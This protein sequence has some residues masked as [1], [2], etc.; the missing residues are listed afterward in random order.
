MITFRNIVKE[1]STA[2]ICEAVRV[3]PTAVSNAAVANSIPAAWRY[4]LEI[5]AAE[6]GVLIPVSLYAWKVGRTLAEKAVQA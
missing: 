1:L 4:E 3:G 2:A 5:L 6:N